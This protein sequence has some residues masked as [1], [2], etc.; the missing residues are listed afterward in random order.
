MLANTPLR[1]GSPSRKLYSIIVASIFFSTLFFLYSSLIRSRFPRNLSPHHQTT[2]SN[3]SSNNFFD[4]I[5]QNYSSHPLNGPNFQDSFG[6]LGQRVQV[7]TSWFLQ[8]ESSSQLQSQSTPNTNNNLLHAVAENL[9]FAHFPFLRNPRQPND[10]TPATNLRSTYVSGSRGIVIPVGTKTLRYAIHL[11]INIRTVLRSRLPIQIFYAGEDDLPSYAQSRLREVEPDIEFFDILTM[12]DDNSMGLKRDWAIKPFAALASIFEQ[13]ILLDADSVWLQKPE[14]LFD[15]AG[16]KSLGA[17]FFHDRLLWQHGFQD[18]HKWWKEQMKGQVPSA[19]LKKSLVWT[20]DYA[21]EADSGV[22]VLDKSRLPLFMGLLH[23]CW[24]NTKAVREPVTYK[25]TYGD[26]ESWWFGLELCGV[27]YA[28]EKHYGAVLGE[29]RW[30]DDK[31]EVCGF[32]IAHLDESDRLIWYN[33]SL[34]K[35]KAV[36]KKEFQIPLNWMIDSKWKKGKT[37]AD[38]SCMTGGLAQQLTLDEQGIIMKSIELAKKADE[39]HNLV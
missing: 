22:V 39:E 19:T 30:Q 35:N 13:V 12:F 11:I 38:M 6:E 1:I 2:T 24:Q 3:L 9:T 20:E 28:F 18:R 17:L 34:L 23:V 37:K 31:A 25:M 27:P 26:K 10:P 36:D 8:A 32:T 5:A 33:G 4:P 21:E 29:T 15:D 14:V 7:L 16:Y